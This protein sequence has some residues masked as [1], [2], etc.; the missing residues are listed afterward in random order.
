MA[1]G[2][3][4]EFETKSCSSLFQ[5]SLQ[6]D[7]KVERLPNLTEEA[8]SRPCETNKDERHSLQRRSQDSRRALRTQRVVVA[9]GQ[10]IGAM[11][12]SPR[13]D[14]IRLNGDGPFE[15]FNRESKL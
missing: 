4:Y 5:H 7:K 9:A 3:S 6:I 13:R 10:G 12:N 15:S 2:L 8:S 14:T 1:G 11:F